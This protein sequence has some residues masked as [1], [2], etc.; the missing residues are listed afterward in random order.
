MDT[1]NER[2]TDIMTQAAELLTC[3][4]EA[5]AFDS[6][7]EGDVADLVVQGL[8]QYAS[9][10]DSM[11]L[12]AQASGD[13]GL[14]HVCVHYQRILQSLAGCTRLDEEARIALEEWPTL[15]MT[16]LEAPQD[17]DICLALVTHLENPVWP[18]PLS[19]A[20]AEALQHL[21]VPSAAAAPVPAEADV[22]CPAAAETP[23]DAVV[24]ALPPAAQADDASALPLTM[25]ALPTFAHQP[26]PHSEH[27]LPPLPLAGEGG[28]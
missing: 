9:Q 21:L 19:L 5:C 15:V 11:A 25:P 27:V 4:L 1:V 10:V 18:T 6:I 23:H 3:F 16:Y 26:S 13:V 17:L 14:S 20:E 24:P 7:G 2:S 8:T 22:C 28:G 12:T